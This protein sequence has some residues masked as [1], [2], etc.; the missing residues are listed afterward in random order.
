MTYPENKDNDY[1][2]AVEFL[3]KAKKSGLSC[4]IKVNDIPLSTGDIKH[5][6]HDDAKEDLRVT[7]CQKLAKWFVNRANYNERMQDQNHH[8]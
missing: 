3:V 5:N 8:R 1:E 2:R 6:N 4:S 7:Y